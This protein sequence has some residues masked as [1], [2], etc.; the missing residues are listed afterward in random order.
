MSL[1]QLLEQELQ[2][3]GQSRSTGSGTI[4]LRDG[5]GNELEIEYAS[6]DSMSGAVEELRLT[7]PALTNISFTLLQKWAEGLSRRI[8]YLLEQIGPLEYDAQAGEALIRS[9]PPGQLPQGAVYYEFLLKTSSRQ[10]ITLNRFR[11]TAGQPGRQRVPM[12][13]THEVLV[14]LVRDLL[15]TLPATP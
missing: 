5:Q 14:R 9:T 8:T 15:D 3:L 4:Q 10:S 12:M 1:P 11:A 6:L 2:R 13:L 7:I